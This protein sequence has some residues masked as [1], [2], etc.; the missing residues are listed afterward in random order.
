MFRRPRKTLL[1]L[2]LA[3]LALP[4]A[5]AHAEPPGQSAFLAQVRQA[6]APYRNINVAAQAGWFA[7]DSFCVSGP[8]HGAM[9]VHVVN[10]ALIGGNQPKVSQPQ[11]LIYEPQ[12]NGS[13]VLVGVEY[14]VI[15]DAWNAHHPDGSTPKVA[16]QL[17]NL[18]PAPNR[19]GLPSVY[20][21]HAWAWQNNPDGNFADWNHHVTCQ[22]QPLPPLS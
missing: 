14:V 13:M 17:M 20:E 9:G 4:A 18:I 10:P 21:L 5:L 6:T 7:R 19:Y 15:A 8:D 12:A 2:G 16:G 11:I 1:T 3:L 22:K